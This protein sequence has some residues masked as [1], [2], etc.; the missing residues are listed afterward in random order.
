MPEKSARARA[1]QGD[2]AK[3]KPSSLLQQ[4]R[5]ATAI[6]VGLVIVLAGAT[7]GWT[8]FEFGLFGQQP[9]VEFALPAVQG[10]DD[11]GQSADTP[12]EELPADGAA[13]P[14]AGTGSS[15]DAA[16]QEE[17][18][19][20]TGQEM[21]T[22]VF[23]ALLGVVS[24][25]LYN[26][27]QWYRRLEDKDPR[28]KAD[29]IKHTYWYVVTLVNA[30]FLTVVVMALLSSATIS[31]AEDNSG[32]SV[33]FGDLNPLLQSG[34]AFILGYYSRTTRA[35]LNL[36]AK[37]LLPRAWMM[38]ENKFDVRGPKSV[39]LGSTG[40]F[41]VEP[42]ADVVWNLSDSAVTIDP[43]S[44]QLSAPADVTQDGKLITVR[45]ALRADQSIS[46]IAETT[47]RAIRITAVPETAA[48]GETVTLGIETMA[49]L[50][51]AQTA[52]TSTYPGLVLSALPGMAP[53]A[54]PNVQ[55]NKVR[56]E[57]V[58]FKVPKLLDGQPLLIYATLESAGKTYQAEALDFK[59]TE[60]S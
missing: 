29:F 40:A 34:L 56:G 26:L 25:L 4:K 50:S 43:T 24:Y 52:W 45:A 3:K 2:P 55:D 18:T 21:V 27:S 8:V 35:Q 30:P 16:A 59:V 14:G 44:G 32:L 51:K 47:L 33:A 42:P 53:A 15:S 36:F 1:R 57:Q 7:F 38:A 37:A 6:F 31:L 60:K 20:L 13:D 49:A 23:A 17:D 22:W 54:D 48:V 41:S 39:M 58:S 19:P 46:A 12:V 5:R 28:N 11:A 9:Q 10:A